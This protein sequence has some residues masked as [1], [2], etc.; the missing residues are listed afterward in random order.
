[1]WFDA[2]SGVLTKE[3]ERIDKEGMTE[4]SGAFECFQLSR[5]DVLEAVLDD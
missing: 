5:I 2:S 4:S 3:V 1:M